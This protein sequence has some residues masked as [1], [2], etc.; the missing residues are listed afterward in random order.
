MSGRN[1]GATGA[2]QPAEQDIRP[3][4]QP[5]SWL[6]SE[7]KR[8]ISFIERVADMCAGLQTCLQ[9][10]HS[11]DLAMQARAMDDDEAMP[12][13]GTV[14]RERMLRLAIAVTGMLADGAHSE[15][16]WENEIAHKATK[17]ST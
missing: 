17:G 9:L 1:D 7:A 14:D 4:H 16:E 5:F 12:I 6:H 8:D 13:L 2:C 11:T 3:I 10:V 15:I